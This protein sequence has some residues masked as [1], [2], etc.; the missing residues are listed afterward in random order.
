MF[1]ESAHNQNCLF[2]TIFKK[3]KSI[4]FP[5]GWWRHDID[6]NNIKVIE[7]CQ[8][9]VKNVDDVVEIVCIKKVVVQENMNVNVFLIHSLIDKNK[10]NLLSEPLS[11]IAE[12]ENT[13]EDFCNGFKIDNNPKNI[14]TTYC[15]SDKEDILC[16][17]GA[18]T[19]FF[20]TVN[21]SAM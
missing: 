9:I 20:A 12:V 16:A 15:Y 4:D 1:P 2:E 21:S 14:Q 8:L 6:C 10:I 11:S 17:T 3:E 18:K 7:F 13:L 19:R 5:L